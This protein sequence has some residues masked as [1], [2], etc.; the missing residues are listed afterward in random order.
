MISEVSEINLGDY[1]QSLNVIFETKKN[2]YIGKKYV[3]NDGTS[4]VISDVNLDF[5]TFEIQP[6]S[7]RSGGKAILKAVY[8]Y[9]TADGEIKESNASFIPD[10]SKAVIRETQRGED[11]FSMSLTDMID[12]ASAT[13]AIVADGLNG[14]A[15]FAVAE[16]INKRKI[17]D[18]QKTPEGALSIN[19]KIGQEMQY[20][21]NLAAKKITENQLEREFKHI[22]GDSPRKES[23]SLMVISAYFPDIISD[24]DIITGGSPEADELGLP[25]T[26]Q[27]YRLKRNEQ[28][29]Q[30]LKPI[31][32]VILDT[33][34]SEAEIEARLKR[35][36]P[37]EDTNVRFSDDTFNFG[38][39]VVIP[40]TAPKETY[41]EM[42]LQARPDLTMEDLNSIEEQ[43]NRSYSEAMRK[44]GVENPAR[45]S[46]GNL[47]EMLHEVYRL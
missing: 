22:G 6:G 11:A 23:D 42:I 14:P 31:Q 38:N 24:V 36:T 30:I 39:N 35:G 19:V 45:L 43:A 25:E 10:A 2:K 21:L 12:I 16:E 28:T 5:N 33:L 20:N 3:A 40:R 46:D 13:E 7:E 37:F 9:K 15:I 18:L 44:K 47:L 8:T 17:N 29:N 32:T 26:G 34:E 27:F 4:G 41:F 1:N